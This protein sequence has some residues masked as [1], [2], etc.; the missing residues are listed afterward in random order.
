VAEDR[1]K[2]SAGSSNP[3][4]D[5][6]SS[7]V[8]HTD[9]VEPT[10][11]ELAAQADPY[12]DDDVPD[13]DVPGDDVPELSEQP[14][15]P[16]PIDDTAADDAEDADPVAGDADDRE[17]ALVGAASAKRSSAATSG[18]DVQTA[19]A[20]RGKGRATPKQ[21]RSVEKQRRTGPVK[22]I[23]ESVAELRKVVYP[24]GSQLRTYFVVV[25]VFVL[26][27]IAFVSLLDL[28]FGALILKVFG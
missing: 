11:D 24:T 18:R 22:F 2:G 28:A 23:G 26:F 20:R 17:P 6:Q 1:D 10:N 8:E 7:P 12:A 4:A 9:A 13:D 25:L 16:G 15:A 14:E 19:D 27:V 21:R 5:D 3:S